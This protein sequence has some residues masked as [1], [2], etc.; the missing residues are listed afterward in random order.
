MKQNI[1]LKIKKYMI[2]FL[3][4]KQIIYTKN[5]NY[6]LKL[7]Y[8]LSF[9]SYLLIKIWFLIKKACSVFYLFL[10]F[11]TMGN[12]KNYEPVFKILFKNEYLH[13]KKNPIYKNLG[14]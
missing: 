5:K 12:T 13:L 4:L 8:Q 6:I 2:F 3:Y 1:Y 14:I 10:K 9:F 11:V 7:I